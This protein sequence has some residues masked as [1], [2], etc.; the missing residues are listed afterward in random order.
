MK[1]LFVTYRWGRDLTGGAEIHHRR[2]ADDLVALGHEVHV[3][4][5]T[6]RDLPAVAHWGVDWQAGYIES[7]EVDEEGIHLRRFPIDRTPRML[8]GLAAKYLERCFDDVHYPSDMM[9]RLLS[10]EL[11]RITDAAEL[12]RVFLWE[13]WHHPEVTPLGL[14]RWSKSR[15]SLVVQSE[16]SSTQPRKL[17][18]TGVAPDKKKLTVSHESTTL[19]SE[20]VSGEFELLVPLPNTEEPALLLQLETSAFR[21]LKDHR[22]LGFFLRS[23]ELVAED[24]PTQPLA[25]ANLAEDLRAVGRRNF[26]IWMQCLE[27]RAQHLTP[28]LCGMFD[29]LRGPRSKALKRALEHIPQDVDLVVACNFPWSIIP[30]VAEHCQKPWAAMALWHLEDEY[31]AWPHYFQALKKA[32]FVLANT[33]FSAEQFFK[34]HGINAP[35]I[36]PGIPPLKPG[37]TSEPKTAEERPFTVLTVC[38]KSGE[39]RYD[40][41]IEAVALLREEG[42]AIEFTLIGPDADS[43]PVPEWVNYRGR[44][45]DDELQAAYEDCNVFALLSETESFGMVVAEAWL[46]GKPVIVNRHC[47]PVASLVEEG[48]NGFAVASAKEC[49]ER[50]R[51]LALNPEKGRQLGAQGKQITERQYL[52]R[53]ATERFLAAIEE[54]GILK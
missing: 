10:E 42:L 51:D 12:P 52:Q 44:V 30:M 19:C 16:G 48:V 11:K 34:P 41:V 37:P 43:L 26:P 49:A 21:P 20:T 35:F 33:P 32:R 14:A 17:L 24:A 40:L 39:K 53:A 3:W 38:R 1:F 47:G 22:T 8:L 9:E 29:W 45:S 31:Y 2:L 54:A 13:G 4:T 5:T 28:H 7:D 50:L 27:Q 25:S 18:I 23:V 6:G 36:G 46:H 15:A